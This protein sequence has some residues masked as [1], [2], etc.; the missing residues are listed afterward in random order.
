MRRGVD[1]AVIGETIIFELR[2]RVARSLQGQPSVMTDDHASLWHDYRDHV[3]H[4][5]SIVE[6]LLFD[7][8]EAKIET[9]LTHLPTGIT[10]ALWLNTE[11]GWDAIFTAGWNYRNGETSEAELGDPPH[12]QMIQDLTRL[13]LRELAKRA[14][15][16]DMQ[17]PQ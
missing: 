10:K 8:I 14:E 6:K 1:G 13:I 5:T 7:F 15:E 11:P 9:E 16:E 2:D 12:D 4:G 17:A 3:A